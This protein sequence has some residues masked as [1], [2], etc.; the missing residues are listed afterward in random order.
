M[1]SHCLQLMVTIGILCAYVLGHFF[2]LNTFNSI[3]A[4]LPL[5]FGAGFVWFPESPYYHIMKNR[6]ESAEKSLKW[7]RGSDYNI[8]EELMDIQIEHSL[9]MQNQSS[10]LTILSKSATKR[11]LTISLV[12]VFLIQFSG[13]NAVIF[14][15]SEIFGM[16]NTGISATVATIIV[17]AMQVA[18]TFVASMTVDSLGRKFLLSI[19]ASI[20]CICNILLGVYFLLQEHKSPYLD[21][22]NLLPIFALC[23]YIIAFS[24]GCGPVPW[25]LVSEIFSTDAKAIASSLT[26]STSWLIAFWVTKFFT[27][28]KNI[29]GVGQTFF[30]FAGFAAMCT[31]FVVSIVPE[32]KGKT[33][34]EIQRSLNGDMNESVVDDNENTT[35]TITI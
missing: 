26:G 21:Y 24:L 11:A 19:S 23:V 18:A 13:I 17:G 1:S 31:L 10:A 30:M 6:P 9:M 14:Y 27:N 2:P 3:C 33:F 32:T 20:M 12:L 28:I 22:L 34:N 29:I 16:A 25:V 4:I 8:N 7:L 35:T 15:T 5:I